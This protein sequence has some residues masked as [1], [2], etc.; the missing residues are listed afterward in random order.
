MIR[1]DTTERDRL[2]Q[3]FIDE[4]LTAE[5]RIALLVRLGREQALRDQVLDLERVLLHVSKLQR[6]VVPSRFVAGVMDQIEPARTPAPPA[7]SAWRRLLRGLWQ[8]HT[9]RWNFAGAL[10]AAVV[11]V[12]VVG[13]VASRRSNVPPSTGSF[14]AVASPAGA[15]V[16]VRLVVLQPDARTVD[17]AGDFNGWDPARTPLEQTANGAWAVTIPLQPG[18]YE[19]MFV[20]DGTHW[21]GD[22]FAVEETDDGFGSRNA[23]LDVRPETEASL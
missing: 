16:L 18:R 23:V 20:V 1:E 7:P 5:E 12:L 13:G 10:A 2:V 21:V 6:P 19:Y 8:P 22:P 9:L 3:R 4:E 15:P 11:L 14:A 17:V